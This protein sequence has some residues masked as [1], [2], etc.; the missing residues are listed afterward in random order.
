MKNIKAA[1]RV[2]LTPHFFISA[3]LYDVDYSSY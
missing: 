1:K 2:F 3:M